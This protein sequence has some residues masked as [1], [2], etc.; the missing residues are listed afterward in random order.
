MSS[1]DGF[2]NY[3]IFEDGKVFSIKRNIIMKPHIDKLGYYL[4]TLTHDNGKSI[5]KKIHR[6]LALTFIPNPENKPVVDHIDQ[7]K[8]NNN[9]NNLRWATLSENMQ[10][11]RQPFNNNKLGE[12]YISINQSRANNYYEFK[13]R[14]N[15]NTI[16]KLFKTLQEAIEFRDNF[17]KENNLISV[18]SSCSS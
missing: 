7:N 3:L 11:I 17:L 16:V 18:T 5:K 15:G 14:F 13:K 2:S 1:I 12:K 4:V 6:L 10:N 8:T 9:I